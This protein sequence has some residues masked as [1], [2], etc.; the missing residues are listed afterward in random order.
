MQKSESIENEHSTSV[1]HFVN[2]H[3]DLF[4]LPFIPLGKIEGG[5]CCF[6]LHLAN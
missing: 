3:F 2:K 5:N 4:I 1:Y 6:L